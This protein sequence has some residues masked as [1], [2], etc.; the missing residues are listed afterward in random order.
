MVAIS[1]VPASL[2]GGTRPQM[3]KLYLLFTIGNVGTGLSEVLAKV[4]TKWVGKRE[5][6]NGGFIEDCTNMPHLHRSYCKCLLARAFPLGTLFPPVK[7]LPANSWPR[8]SMRT[9]KKRSR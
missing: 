3:Q 5:S 8:D 2:N 9:K 1:D 7:G 6:E 4:V